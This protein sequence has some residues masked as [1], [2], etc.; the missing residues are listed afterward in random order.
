VK[1][2]PFGY[3]STSSMCT[4]T[5]S[6]KNRRGRGLMDPEEVVRAA[7]KA[8]ASLDMDQVMAYFSEDATLC[9]AI[10]YPTWS[11]SEAIREG[12]GVF[13]KRMT[14]C[15]IEIVNL[16]VAGTV[17]L[18][19]RIDHIVFD[20]KAHD[21]SGM[22]AFEIAGDKITAWRDYFAPDIT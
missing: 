16:A 2:I 6:M 13:F 18:T 10:G 17:V 15:D 19:E 3:I 8:H 22:G 11:G 20:G 4:D 21:A 7:M 5:V 1:L 9:P 12:L 14:R